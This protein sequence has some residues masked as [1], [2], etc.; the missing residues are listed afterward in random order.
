MNC[1]GFY[2]L[3]VTLVISLIFAVL[4]D[5]YFSC[6]S[7]QALIINPNDNDLTVRHKK[8]ALKFYLATV[9]GVIIMIIDSIILINANNIIESDEIEK[10]SEVV[11]SIVMEE[12]SNHNDYYCFKEHLVDN[13][14]YCIMIKENYQ[15][16]LLRMPSD[17]C[18]INETN[19]TT[20]HI[21]VYKKVCRDGFI[22]W[23]TGAR[24]SD[25]GETYY[26][27]YVPKGTV[28]YY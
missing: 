4:G 10:R 23:F 24:P 22:L 20:P 13:C 15:K 28:R 11:N 9:I 2:F 18:S 16:F 6:T 3:L 19:N 26:K 5:Y 21:D 7:W 25:L 12:N 1:F 27:V 17:K 8:I 14:Y